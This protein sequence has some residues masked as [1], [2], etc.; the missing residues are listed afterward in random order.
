MN[1]RELKPTKER[2]ISDKIREYRLS[3]YVDNKRLARLLG[4]SYE[5]FQKMIKSDSDIAQT[6]DECGNEIAREIK[7]SIYQRA[8]GYTIQEL[9]IIAHFDEHGRPVCNKLGQHKIV[10]ITTKHIPADARCAEMALNK[11]DPSWAEGGE[12]VI[13]IDD[14]KAIESNNA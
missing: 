9:K 6:M 2:S 4:M 7:A 14:I 5:S 12:G 1:K 11:L 13:I 10:E 3:R 8:I